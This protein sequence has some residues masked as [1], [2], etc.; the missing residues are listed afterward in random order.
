MRNV[1]RRLAAR[2]FALPSASAP[3]GAYDS[4]VVR[5]D[6]AR[7]AIQFPIRD[8]DFL[9]RGRLGADLT[10]AD[11]RAAMELCALNVLAQLDA[12]LAG[13]QLLGLDHLDAYYV[14]APGWDEAPRVLDAASGLLRDVLGGE[15]GRHTRALAGVAHLPRDFCVGLV[16]SATLAPAR[17]RARRRPGVFGR[18]TRR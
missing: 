6:R 14:A 17:E 8:G 15:A 16:A 18:R 3:G 1:R 13:R 5:G 11:G 9:Y 7:V 4:L 12:K 10:T 2:G